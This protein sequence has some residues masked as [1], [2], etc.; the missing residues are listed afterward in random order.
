MTI[1]NMN[2][3]KPRSKLQ[4]NNNTALILGI[5]LFSFGII[6]FYLNNYYNTNITSFLPRFIM[7]SIAKTSTGFIFC[8]LPFFV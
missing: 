8:P 3:F 2:F 7:G 6:D 1:N 4:K 5:L